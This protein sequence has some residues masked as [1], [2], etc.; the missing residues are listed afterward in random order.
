MDIKKPT[1]VDSNGAAGLFAYLRSRQYTHYTA[2][3]FG[4]GVLRIWH[5][6]SQ[7]TEIIENIESIVRSRI[8]VISSERMIFVKTI[9]NRC[10]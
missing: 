3:N 6:A 7:I 5:C 4:R 1:N 8:H 2:I 10:I 9:C